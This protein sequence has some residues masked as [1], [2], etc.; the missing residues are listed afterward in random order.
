MTIHSFNSFI[1]SIHSFIQ[2]EF[3]FNIILHPFALVYSILAV[4]SYTLQSVTTGIS[5][6]QLAPYIV[7]T[8]V[9][10]VFPMLYFASHDHF[11]TTNLY[12]SIPS[13]FSPS[14]PP[15][16]SRNVSL[17]LPL[18]SLKSYHFYK[19]NATEHNKI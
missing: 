18:S 17:I 3:T 4:Q 1:H 10:T 15:F 14:P 12:F 16:P 6:I 11:I 2:L 7:I 19:S 8:V 9:L 13:P 5:R